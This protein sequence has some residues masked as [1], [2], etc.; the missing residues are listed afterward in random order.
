M[1]CERVENTLLHE[2]RGNLS[3]LSN[4]RTV[5]ELILSANVNII[6]VDTVT[7]GNV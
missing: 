6:Y 2:L 7:I 1:S 4:A 5:K 3:D